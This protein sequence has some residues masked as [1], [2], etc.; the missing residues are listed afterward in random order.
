M[1]TREWSPGIFLAFVGLPTH[2]KKVT[3]YE[4]LIPQP[5]EFIIHKSSYN[6]KLYNIS[7]RKR[8]LINQELK[9]KKLRDSEDGGFVIMHYAEVKVCFAPTDTCNWSNAEYNKVVQTMRTRVLPSRQ[10][11]TRF[12]LGLVYLVNK[13]ESNP[14]LCITDVQYR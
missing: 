9:K 3:G 2:A 6:S 10:N 13:T 8:R 11:I 4:R 1:E 12:L 5:F 14:L 7:N